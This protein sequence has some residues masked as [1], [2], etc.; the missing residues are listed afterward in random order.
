MA[1]H[2]RANHVNFS[3]KQAFSVS[4]R[5]KQDLELHG[6]IK[7]SMS[8]LRLGGLR[9]GLDPMADLESQARIS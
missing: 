5:F 9:I 4:V 2:H 3:A 8:N 7:L 1:N 6:A